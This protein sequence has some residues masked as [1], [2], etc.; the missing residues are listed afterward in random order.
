M[1]IAIVGAGVAGLASAKVLH[2][3]GHQVSVFERCGDL[4]GVW[5]AT[6]RYPGLRTQNVKS[7]YAYS[8][9]P[10]PRNVPEFPSADQVQA[11]LSAYAAH[12]GFAGRIRLGTEV[13]FAGLDGHAGSWTVRTRDITRGTEDG[14]TYDHLVV[15]NGVY[16]DCL[17]PDFAGAGDFSRQGGRVLHSSQLTD[18]DQARG[19]HVVVLGYGKSACDVAEAVSDVAASTTVVARHLQWK[20]PARMAGV[21]SYKYLLL[22]RFGEGL[23]PYPEPRG[24]AR[25]LH[26]GPYPLAPRMLAVVQS[27]VT[28]QDRLRELDLV[29]DGTFGDIARGTVSLT[30]ERFFTKVRQGRIA[31]HR[32]A[33]IAALGHGPEGSPGTGPDAGRPGCVL[34]DGTRLP[35]DLVV[36][37][38]GFRR[39]LPFLDEAV[40][41]RV[42][43]EE[44]NVVLYRH[45][46]PPEVPHLTFSGYN[47]S[48][49]CPLGS[50]IAALWTAR[51][52]EGAIRLPPAQE[53]RRDAVKRLGWMEQRSDG[54]HANGASVIPFSMH[55]I[56]DMLGDLGLDVP[57]ATRL[58][59]WLLPIDPR[60]YAEMEPRLLGA[61]RR[62]GDGPGTPTSAPRSVG[63]GRPARRRGSERA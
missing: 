19:R 29:P 24:V 45:I 34:T 35:A 62:S 39:R 58:R 15:A 13:V 40:R 17:V 12:F 28:R 43:D 37:G 59:Q 5:S 46:V 31:V 27:V 2:R 30:T 11:Y 38:T 14:G 50:E 60:A 47:S 53:M 41:R 25:W 1:R 54:K 32:G 16:S 4:G 49:F 10:F 55:N 51:L 42:T 52:L 33:G 7:T 21:L 18:L 48:F 8:D 63:R 26:A 22:T 9:F 61:S 6:R 44:G 23:F 57:R 56:D 36:C 20:M 3:F